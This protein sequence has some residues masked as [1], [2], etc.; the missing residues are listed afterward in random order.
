MPI[1]AQKKII[2][3]K[4]HAFFVGMLLFFVLTATLQAQRLGGGLMVGPVFSTMQLSDNDST[5]FTMGFTGGLRFAIIPEHSI[6]GA[7]IDLLY[8][9]QGTG[10]KS[11]LNENGNRHSFSSRSS[12]VNVPLLLNFYFRR[13]NEDDED[14]SK[15][16]RLRV[17]PQIGFCIG[18]KDVETVKLSRQN[19]QYIN[20]W[21]RGTYNRLDY[22]ITAALAYWHIEVRYTYS[23]P[24]VL[25][26]CHPSKNHVI[27]LTWSA[28]W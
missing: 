7:E 28:I 8:S 26:D 20:P 6:I 2:T 11:G 21:E 22:S 10:M 1:F 3:V 5:R 19:K 14:E 18:G 23:F 12:Y 4:K 27:S 17:G 24:D 15:M 13:W 9:R 16:V 25:K